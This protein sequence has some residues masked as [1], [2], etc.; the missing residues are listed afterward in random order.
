MAVRTLVA[1]IILAAAT[2]APVFA[3]VAIRPDPAVTPGTLNPAV[4]QQTI[5]RTICRRGWTTTVRP[6]E[7]F[8]ERLK[9]EQ[10]YSAGSPYFAAGQRL[11]SFEEDHDVPLGLGGAPADPRNLWPQPRFGYWNARVKDRLEDRLHEMV[12]AGEL[13][14]AGAQRA[15]AADW[16][17]AY[18]RYLGEP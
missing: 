16:I 15:I 18:R 2:S 9:R 5:R 13:P 14:L 8:T 17:A 3:A 6:P 1:A 12:C 4:A 11:R 10:L 7:A